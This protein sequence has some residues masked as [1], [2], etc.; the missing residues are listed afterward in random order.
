MGVAPA[1]V[2]AA[3]ADRPSARAAFLRDAARAHAGHSVGERLIVIV[4]QFEEVFTLGEQGAAGEAERV[5]FIDLLAA[6]AAT[7]PAHPAPLALVVCGL[8]SDFYTRCPDYPSLRSALQDNQVFV[9]PMSPAEVRQAIEQPAADVGLRVEPGLTDLLLRDLG[10]TE[11]GGEGRDGY[12]AGRLPLLAFVL[13]ALWR[14]RDGDTL[15]V[16]AYRESGGIQDAVARAADTVF[17]ELGTEGQRVAR[18]VLLRLV[19][20]GEGGPVEDARRRRDYPDLLDGLDPQLAARVLDT[21]TDHRLLTR[22]RDTVEI[23]HDALL[24]AWPRLR[25]WIEA[26][27]AG[28]LVRQQLE[29][30]AQAWQRTGHDTALL[31]R[32]HRLVAAQDWAGRTPPARELG[33]T[34]TAFLTASVRQQRRATRQRRAVLAGLTVLTLVASGTA[35]YAFQQQTQAQSNF[36]D[37]VFHEVT[38]EADNVRTGNPALAADLDLIAYRMRSGDPTVVRN[39]EY[40]DNP[41]VTVGSGAAGMAFGHHDR[42]LVTGGVPGPAVWNLTDPTHP[43][44]LGDAQADAANVGIAFSA[45]DH[46]VATLPGAGDPTVPLWNVT[47]PTHPMPVGRLTAANGGADSV[48]FS[49]TAAILAIGDDSGTVSL[50]NIAAPTHPTLAGKAQDPRGSLT[51]SLAFTPSG[52]MLA[53]YDKDGAVPLWNVTDPTH[54]VLLGQAL[55]TNSGGDSVAVSPNAHLLVTGDDDGWVRLWDMADPA[56]PKPIGQVRTPSAGIVYSVALSPDGHTVAAADEH[57]NLWLWDVTNPAH[58]APVGQPLA[59]GNGTITS[60]A[61]SQDGHDLAASTG[62]GVVLWRLG[63]DQAIQRICA[64]ARTAVTPRYGGRTSDRRCRSTR[65]ADILGYPAHP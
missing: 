25:D 2:T 3:L 44:K 59:G 16:R 51:V 56:T 18:I 37:A 20:I 53:A 39:V 9:G 23:T 63:L 52:G 4:D 41:P 17:A 45:D 7:Q 43:A 58:P 13:P 28:N 38:T 26:D 60:V 10:V 49:P 57:G 15:T 32:G 40:A 19:T 24:R 34:A 35:V 27:R 50:W 31:Y 30:D 62:S 5:R 8:R 42:T 61:F 11:T 64:T 48:A 21:F 33:P 46:T 1:E 47:D 29:D 12:E 36:N 6:L 54:P 65:P 14:R 55:A 22:E